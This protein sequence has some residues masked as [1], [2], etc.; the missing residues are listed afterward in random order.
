[1]RTVGTWGCALLLLAGCGDVDKAASAGKT[2][3][4]DASAEAPPP[5]ALC[6]GSAGLRL[7]ARGDASGNM[8]DM[9]P[10]FMYELGLYYL[11]VSGECHY[12][13][14]FG[15]LTADPMIPAPPHY[16]W[17]PTNEGQLSTQDAA[18]LASDLKYSDWDALGGV[19]WN[20]N[21]VIDAAFTVLHDQTRKVVCYGGCVN[22]G[23][24]GDVLRKAEEVY[25][26]IQAA[27]GWIVRLYD[28]G[29]PVDGPMRI[30]VTA[31]RNADGLVWVPWPLKDPID[32]FVVQPNPNDPW[33]VPPSFLITDPDDTRA[34]RQLRQDRIN[35]VLGGYDV[36]G[37]AA[38]GTAGPWFLY[39]R[40]TVPFEDDT[41]Q[42]PTP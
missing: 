16:L 28:A 6:D 13:T 32:R 22:T 5:L 8:Q 18:A 12:W 25:A 33:Y 9:G 42:V 2:P 37:I 38:Q 30:I 41:G 19:V 23:Y 26:A 21:T 10:L 27:R 11:F 24:Q 35:D 36:I 3:S 4:G 20:D 1:M 15:G 40:D 7:A 29:T 39:M 34:L 14:W 31:P 17:Y